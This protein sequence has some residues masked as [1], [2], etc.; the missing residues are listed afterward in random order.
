VLCAFNKYYV[1]LQNKEEL[2]SNTKLY[3]DKEKENIVKNEETGIKRLEGAENLHTDNQNRNEVDSKQKSDLKPGQVK[4]P[5][6]NNTKDLQQKHKPRM[7]VKDVPFHMVQ[8]KPVERDP[9][10]TSLAPEKTDDGKVGSVLKGPDQLDQL[11][12]YIA[13]QSAFLECLC[14]CLPKV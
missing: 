11:K 13:P 7:E 8:L 2:D 14:N 10:A 9:K 5:G 12:L 1:T 6:T 3:Q 4:K